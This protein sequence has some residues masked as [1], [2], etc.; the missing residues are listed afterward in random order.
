MAKLSFVQQLEEW[1]FD[2]N[3]KD[4]LYILRWNHDGDRGK[5]FLTLEHIRRLFKHAPTDF[6]SFL[7]IY[8]ETY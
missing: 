4:K 5:I 3:I 2:V 7:N 1:G 8:N 6:D